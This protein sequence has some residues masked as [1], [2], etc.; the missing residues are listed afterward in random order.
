VRRHSARPGEPPRY[1]VLDQR[2]AREIR[3]ASSR[4]RL[5]LSPRDSRALNR[6]VFVADFNVSVSSDKACTNSA[7]LS[8]KASASFCSSAANAT[9]S[10][11]RLSRPR[12]LPNRCRWATSSAAP[13]TATCA[14]ADDCGA[15][16]ADD[17]VVRGEGETAAFGNLD[18]CFAVRG[19]LEGAVVRSAVWSF[20]TSGAAGAGGVLSADCCATLVAGITGSLNLER[21]L[22]VAVHTPISDSS[23]RAAT[24]TDTRWPV[25]RRRP[26]RNSPGTVVPARGGVIGTRRCSGRGTRP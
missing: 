7:N 15:I 2:R 18:D 17:G 9:P 4:S 24:A 13:A 21:A 23:A 16:G 20:V 1:L 11:V 19:E 5:A 10:R 12:Q 14:A 22:L 8:V 6:Y 26:R 25:A 3:S